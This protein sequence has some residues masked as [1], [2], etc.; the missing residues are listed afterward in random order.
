[1]EGILVKIKFLVFC[2]F[3][4]SLTCNAAG[5]TDSDAKKMIEVFKRDKG[6]AVIFGEAEDAVQLL[7]ASNFFVHLIA[8]KESLVQGFR[9]AIDAKKL[10]HRNSVIFNDVNN[11]LPYADNLINLLVVT[12]LKESQN[13]LQEAWRILAPRGVLFV[14]RNNIDFLKDSKSVG[15]EFIPSGNWVYAIKPVPKSFDNWSHNYGSANQSYTNQDTSVGP[16]DEIR[17]VADPMWGNFYL[18]YISMLSGGGVIFYQEA[19][20]IKGEGRWFLVAR[21]AYNGIELWRENINGFLKYIQNPDY[22]NCCDNHQIYYREDKYQVA[23]DGYT[24]KKVMTYKTSKPPEFCLVEGNVIVCCSKTTLEAFD[25]F[26]GQLLWSMP[27][28]LPP[29]AENGK[30]FIVSENAIKGLDIKSG[31]VL[32]LYKVDNIA[33]KTDSR[34]FCKGE[35]VYISIKK[36]F[37]ANNELIAININSG[38]K[39]WNYNDTWSYGTLPYLDQVW[40]LSYSTKTKETSVSAKIIDST[41]GKIQ[42]EYPIEGTAGG[43]CWGARGSENY[44]IYSSG[45]YYDRKK[46]SGN[47]IGSTRSP[48]RL[49]QIPANGS[50]YFLPHHCD[51]GVQLRGFLS[52]TP[53][54]AVSWEP[55]TLNQTKLTKT[56]P[57]EEV[58][59]RLNDWPIY[60]NNNLRT[61][62]TNETVRGNLN[63]I[64]SK[65]NQGTKLCQT[66][67][68]NGLVYS[69]DVK[70]NKLMVYKEEKGE[71]AWSFIAESAILASP[72]ISGNVCLFGTG[73]GWVYSLD[74]KTGEEFWRFRAAPVQKFI[75]DKNRLESA[76]PVQGGV[77]VKDN[78]AYFAAGRAASQ[79]LGMYMY[80]VELDTGKVVWMQNYNNIGLCADLL[81]ADEKKLSFY[82]E[83]FE[84]KTGK[85]DKGFKPSLPI[86]KT[87]RYLSTVSLLNYF[88]SIDP[89]ETDKRH[90]FLNDG[91]QLG[92]VV[93]SKNKMSV[94]AGR[95]STS[96]DGWKEKHGQYFLRAKG[97]YNWNLEDMDIQIIGMVTTNDKIYA[98]GKNHKTNS[99]T[100]R[101]YALSDGKQLQ[102]ISIDGTPVYDGLS[103]S[104]GRVY[105]ST[106]N[107]IL[108]VFKGE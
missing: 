90:V 95:I 62:T 75:G 19:Q 81:I 52:L 76:W 8:S 50:T 69:A 39:R 42:K 107:G 28:Q 98:A 55:T 84:F 65:K 99:N 67:V 9:V 14:S 44:L 4:A 103:V 64:W 15:L 89:Q 20:K 93:S 29:A 2:I 96:F 11:R 37:D 41:T 47:K 100:L 101:V 34:L 77:L 82:D 92:N 30:I 13:N 102:E 80:G 53:K 83:G 51:C 23:R 54:G 60:R 6:I 38:E 12:E 10:S 27:I 40:L 16:W 73:G 94:V 85:I 87:T 72:T 21:D 63:L 35:N 33:E 70:S 36:K 97:D 48:C 79:D 18:S 17:W 3:L 58:K 1:M 32:W 56:V 26:S 105:L 74:A 78:I 45:W 25:K 71:L 46:Q 108:N 88:E 104:N 24:G 68:A 43:H 66:V 91:V 5:V 106:E 57:A 86:L 31:K 59:L 22:T 49:G 61:N 7:L